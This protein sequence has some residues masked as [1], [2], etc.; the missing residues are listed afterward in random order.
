MNTS[1]PNILARKKTFRLLQNSSFRI[2]LLGF[3]LFLLSSV[4][5][6]RHAAAIGHKVWLVGWAYTDIFHPP[7]YDP[8]KVEH[9]ARMKLYAQFRDPREVLILGHRPFGEECVIYKIETLDSV[10]RKRQH[11]RIVWVHWKPWTMN[12]GTT[13]LREADARQLVNASL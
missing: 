9:I 2:G 12:N 11:E 3:V 8:E 5:I 7:K 6:A 13:I 4:L 10:G 1:R